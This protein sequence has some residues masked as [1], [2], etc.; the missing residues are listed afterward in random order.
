MVQLPLLSIWLLLVAVVA[1][2]ILVAAEVLA[3]Y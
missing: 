1:V 2:H 3:V